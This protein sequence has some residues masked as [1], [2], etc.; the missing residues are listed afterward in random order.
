MSNDSLP[1]SPPP[2]KKRYRAVFRRANHNPFRGNGRVATATQE[3]DV[4]EETPLA[5][6]EEWAREMGEQGYEFVSVEA[7]S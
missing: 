6:V 4:D 7:V 1:P 2:G 5:Q 3:V